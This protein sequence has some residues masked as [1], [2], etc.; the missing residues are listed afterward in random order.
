MIV[1]VI[2]YHGP[3][4]RLFGNISND[5]W[6]YKAID[7]IGQDLENMMTLFLVDFLSIIISAIALWYTCKIDIFKSLGELQKEFWP[8][9]CV[10]IGSNLI[11]VCFEIYCLNITN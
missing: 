9:F 7:N 8:G 10:I 2:T 5:Y 1:Y 6:A 11:V 3:N 4:S